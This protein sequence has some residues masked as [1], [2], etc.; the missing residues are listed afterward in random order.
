MK[1]GPIWEGGGNRSGGGNRLWLDRVVEGNLLW[2]GPI[3][4]RTHLEGRPISVGLNC[5]EG[6][7][8]GRPILA[9]DPNEEWMHCW[10]W[11]PIYGG[12]VRFGRG[13]SVWG[14]CSKRTQLWEDLFCRGGGVGFIK[15]R[16]QCVWICVPGGTQLRWDLSVAGES[17]MG[18][19]QL[20]GCPFWRGDLFKG[21]TYVSGS[22]FRGGPN[23]SGT[24]A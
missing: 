1:D 23:W 24:S 21:G 3:G 2:D 12:G 7:D 22:V 6:G 13:T 5:G 18:R 20:W 14:L 4:G 19:T 9:G 15:S 11:T 17:F 8:L 10:G 16:K